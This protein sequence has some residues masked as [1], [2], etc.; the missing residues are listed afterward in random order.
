MVDI[1]NKL[2]VTKIGNATVGVCPK[3]ALQFS[4][5]LTTHA[6]HMKFSGWGNVKKRFSK[7]GSPK[8]KLLVDLPVRGLYPPRL[9]Y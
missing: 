4:N 7:R 5:F 3:R 1:Q 8:L 2:H 9:R 6:G